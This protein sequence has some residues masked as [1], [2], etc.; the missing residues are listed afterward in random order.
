MLA[1]SWAS[2]RRKKRGASPDAELTGKPNE[3]ER[4]CKSYW[5][6]LTSFALNGMGT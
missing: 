5:P 6:S 4:L 1:R 3:R 2:F